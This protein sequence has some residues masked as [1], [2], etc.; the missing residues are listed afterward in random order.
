MNTGVLGQVPILPTGVS[1][2]LSN[3]NERI[4]ATSFYATTICFQVMG[5]LLM[6]PT[7]SFYMA[8]VILIPPPPLL[9]SQ[10]HRLEEPQN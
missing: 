1:Y 3:N 5:D 7:H 8:N 10:Q 6:D 2:R 9:H 4:M